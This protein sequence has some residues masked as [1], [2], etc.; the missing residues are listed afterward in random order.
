MS[1]TLMFA[2]VHIAL[3]L[4][5]VLTLLY[6]NISLVSWTFVLF[7][8]MVGATLVPCETLT[9]PSLFALW[10]IFIAFGLLNI[11][12]LRRIFITGP[13]FKIFKKI[14]PPMSQTER[15]ALEAG[16]VWWDG[17]LFSGTPKWDKLFDYKLSMLNDVEQS[18][19]DNEVTELCKML[20]DW[21]ITNE[22][23]DL[24]PEVWQYMKDKKFFGMIINKDYGGLGFS[25]Y[26][27]S[28]VV[29][30]VASRSLSAAVT[31]MVPNSLG[32]AELL[33][34]YG[35]KDQ[36]DHYLPRL[37]AGLDVPCFALTAPKAGSDAGAIPGKSVV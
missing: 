18:F 1:E 22:L 6:I 21:K 5:I 27:H 32:P 25:A 4:G 36:K 2:L 11:K 10:A 15:D 37:A 19:L 13:V 30:K 16:S 33:H 9:P 8:A 23:G 17:D 31:V 35:T 14:L 34:R 3:T 24:P 26:C 20:D 29:Q 28:Q 12:P 7:A